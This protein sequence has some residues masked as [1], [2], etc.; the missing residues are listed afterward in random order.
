MK[1]VFLCLWLLGVLLQCNAII[2]LQR[3]G[4][5][6]DTEEALLAV[7]GSDSKKTVV[8]VGGG[9][10]GHMFAGL[11]ASKGHDVYLL[12]STP[13]SAAEWQEAIASGDPLVIEYVNEPG[14]Q[15]TG[16][17][18]GA[19]HDAAI[20][21]K[22]DV[23]IFGGMEAAYHRQN[24]KKMKDYFKPGQIVLMVSGGWLG[25]SEEYLGKHYMEVLF[26]V[27]QSLPWAA[28]FVGPRGKRVEN[29]GAKSVMPLG[30]TGH[31]KH[32]SVIQLM[33]SLTDIDFV[34]SPSLLAVTLEDPA[35]RIHPTLMWGHYR[36]LKEKLIAASKVLLFYQ[37]A[38]P[39]AV[40]VALAQAITLRC[41]GHVDLSSIK[42]T[43]DTLL[44]WYGHSQVSDPSTLLTVY[45]TNE[46]YNGLRTPHTIVKEGPNKGKAKL[47]WTSRYVT[48]DVPLGA[49]VA[50]GIGDLFEQPMPVT[51]FQ[52]L[53]WQQVMDKQ[54]VTSKLG[55]PDLERVKSIDDVRNLYRTLMTFRA[56]GKDIK[57]TMAPQAMNIHSVKEFFGLTNFACT[58]LLPVPPPKAPQ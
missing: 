32:S 49:V 7:N 44:K 47:D 50:K 31:G 18:K 45:Q 15:V 58:Y 16:R 37:G 1:V 25:R 24:L 13:R 9:N 43:Q 33:R 52:I 29:Y 51:T 6:T 54:Y 4:A 8:V 30:L 48:S 34:L 39:E 22:A 42:S 53:Y 27:M 12:T 20:I 57:E 2:A 55:T 21:K 3:A 35:P 56:D 46:P 14:K 5:Q 19:T 17:L 40:K 28:R 11:A 38:R 41:E 23:I 26:G 10:G 36:P